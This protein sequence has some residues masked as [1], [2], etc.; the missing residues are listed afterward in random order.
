MHRIIATCLGLAL[1]LVWGSILNA[2]QPA[3]PL[4]F[5]TILNSGSAGLMLLPAGYFPPG[6]P[7]VLPPSLRTYGLQI[8]IVPNDATSDTLV[9]SAVIETDDGIRKWYSVTGSVN[10]SPGSLWSNLYVPT[11]KHTVVAVWQVSLVVGKRTAFAG[12]Q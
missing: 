2:Q 9:F 10:P 4:P 1:A 6:V 5:A 11:G 12:P 3:A 8:S 7:G